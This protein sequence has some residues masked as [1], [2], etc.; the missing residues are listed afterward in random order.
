MLLICLSMGVCNAHWRL[1]CVSVMKIDGR[2]ILRCLFFLKV[3][4]FQPFKD[5]GIR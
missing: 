3:H 1:E 5:N 2:R 4:V